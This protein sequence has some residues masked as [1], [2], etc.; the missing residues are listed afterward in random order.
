MLTVRY[1]VPSSSKVCKSKPTQQTLQQV[2]N[3]GKIYK[4][5]SSRACELNK[6]VGYYLAKDMQPLYAVERPG[7]NKLVAKL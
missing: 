3:K 7:F 1:V 6:A 5:K 2:I 4:A